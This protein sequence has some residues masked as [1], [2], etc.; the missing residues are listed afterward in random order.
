ML[1]EL[2]ESRLRRR[3]DGVLGREEVWVEDVEADSSDHQSGVYC[4]GE[5]PNLFLV[6]PNVEVPQ[7]SNSNQ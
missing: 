3:Q 5:P 4:D 2:R 1:M 6:G 7:D